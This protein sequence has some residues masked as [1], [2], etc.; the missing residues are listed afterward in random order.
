MPQSELLRFLAQARDD[1]SLWQMIAGG[2]TADEVSLLAQERGF[3]VSGSDILR[4]HGQSGL[5]A[6]EAKADIYPRGRWDIC[7]NSTYLKRLGTL[8]AKLPIQNMMSTIR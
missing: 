1:P 7:T 3:L 6:P 2:L 5:R 4:F 8:T